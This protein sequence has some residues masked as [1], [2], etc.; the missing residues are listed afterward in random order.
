MK[1]LI[2]LLFIS[3]L[4]LSAICGSAQGPTGAQPD[5]EFNLFLLAIT[6]AFVCIVVGAVLVGSLLVILALLVLVGLVTAGIVSA[7]VLVGL[8][9]KSISAGFKTVIAITGCLSG[10]VIGEVA[11]YLINRAFHLHLSGVA[12][13]GI[14]GFCGLVAGLLLGMVLFMLIRVILNYCRA[15]LSF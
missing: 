6:I 4:C 11:F 2:T 14:G 15:K 12:V 1:R 8:Y 9:R 13:V 10:I 7:G 5:D 3:L